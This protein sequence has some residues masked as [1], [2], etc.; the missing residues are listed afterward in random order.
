MPLKSPEVTLLI[1]EDNPGDIA[2]MKLYLRELPQNT[3]SIFLKTGEEA[4][5]YL[6]NKMVDN[7][8]IIVLDLNLPRLSGFELYPIIRNTLGAD[9]PVVIFSSSTSDIDRKKAKDLGIISYLVKPDN[10]MDYK[11]SMLE[12]YNLA[13]K[14]VAA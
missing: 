14:P 7:P 13:V 11:R 10:V 12:I 3:K 5:N 4:R 8:N 6:Q 9:V 1:I 2:L